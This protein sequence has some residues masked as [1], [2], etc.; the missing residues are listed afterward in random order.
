MKRRSLLIYSACLLSSPTYASWFK[1]TKAIIKVL[2]QTSGKAVKKG[3]KF[4]KSHPELM[5]V[6]SVD[7]VHLAELYG[8]VDVWD[9]NKPNKI[10]IEIENISKTVLSAG[11]INI[12]VIDVPTGKI[13]ASGPI[14]QYDNLTPGQPFEL[15]FNLKS[16]PHQGVKKISLSSL[17][18]AF[19]KWTSEN[20]L[21]ANLS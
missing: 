14:L 17:E 19:S 12:E 1:A 2:F 9:N 6:L 10:D 8:V 16:L 7:L 20:L 5:G 18:N 15:T 21:I 13:E 3:S 4:A 11:V